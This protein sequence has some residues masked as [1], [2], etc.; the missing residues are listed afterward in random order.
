MKENKVTLD[1]KIKDLERQVAWFESDDFT[2]EEAV[3]RYE[4][5]KKLSQS[6]A[7]DIEELKNVITVIKKED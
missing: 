4:A 6:I 3:Q 5:A 2:V 7:V 1:D